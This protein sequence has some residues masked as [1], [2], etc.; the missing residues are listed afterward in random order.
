MTKKLVITGKLPSLNEYSNAERRHRQGGARMKKQVESE[1]G[2][3]IKKQLRGVKYSKPVYIAYKWIEPNR[4]RDK[5]NIAFAKKF[6]QDAL[7]RNG[8]LKNDGW[9][10]VSGFSDS[11]DVDKKNPRIEVVI[12]DEV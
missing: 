2:W 11:F 5:D 3:Q 8:V 10:E 6:I 1:I 9:N 12:I 7:V 4:Y